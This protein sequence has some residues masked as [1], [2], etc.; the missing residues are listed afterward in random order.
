MDRKAHHTF[1][2]ALIVSAVWA[3]V[4]ALAP[5]GTAIIWL[6]VAS[7]F[8]IGAT[9]VART[10]F[11]RWPPQLGVA[12]LGLTT[13]VGTLALTHLLAPP[14]LAAVPAWGED[15][16]A[17]YSYEVAGSGRPILIDVTLTALVIIGEELIWRGLA[18]SALRDRLPDALAVPLAAILYAVCQLGF[19]RTLPAVAALA[20]GLVWGLLRIATWQRARLLAPLL[21]HAVWTLGIL[22]LW[23]LARPTP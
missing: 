15:F 13:G 21:A 4:L 6:G 9:V 22:W 20:L 8:A 23:P 19:G 1:S 3:A 12:A 11:L 7:V 18:L 16:R 2:L 5:S 10:P 17:L 14:V